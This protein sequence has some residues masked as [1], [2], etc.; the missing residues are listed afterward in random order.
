MTMEKQNRRRF[1][2]NLALGV[3]AGKAAPAVLMAENIASPGK[4]A[5]TVTQDIIAWDTTTPVRPGY[6]VLYCFEFGNDFQTM[7]PGFQ[8]VSRVYRNSRYLWISDV[9]DTTRGEES[10]P[11]LRNFAQ[12]TEGEFWVGMDD[13]D[14]DVTLIMVDSK[15]AHGPFAI[16]LT[17]PGG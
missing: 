10:A 15:Q 7:T 5:G 1:I 4:P 3:A 8:P 13:G 11:L 14:Y 12:G 6:D 17:G 2:G 9:R 16:Y